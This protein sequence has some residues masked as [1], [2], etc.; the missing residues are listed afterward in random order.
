MKVGQVYLDHAATTPM[1]I[2]VHREMGQYCCLLFGNPA[3]LY[4]LGRRSSEAVEENRH[5]VSELLGCRDD[6]VY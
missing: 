3:T 5:K 6:E 4:S 1:D 2:S